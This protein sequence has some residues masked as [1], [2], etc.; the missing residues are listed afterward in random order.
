MIADYLKPFLRR[1]KPPTVLT[2]KSPLDDLPAIT[3]KV[4]EPDDHRAEKE[5]KRI[6]QDELGKMVPA[7]CASTS[8]RRCARSSSEAHPCRPR[9]LLRRTICHARGGGLVS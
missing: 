8:E 3:I 9:P 7:R 6:G 5:V 4:E 2:L 1:P